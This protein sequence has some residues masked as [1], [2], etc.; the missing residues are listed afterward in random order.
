MT[1][2]AFA[3]ALRLLG[4]RAFFTAELV[5]RLRDKGYSG[6]EVREA[7]DRCRELGYL[8]DA[9]VAARFVELRAVSRG[10]GPR[11]LRAE[12]LKRGA[13][14]EVAAEASRLDPE[15]GR[16][17]LANALERAERRAPEGWWRLHERRARMVSSLINR[18]F[19]TRAAIEAVDRLAAEREK[20][21]HAIDDER[22][23]PHD[24]P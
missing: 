13:P 11:R 9:A 1:R 21:D 4:R 2:S 22:G 19:D 15:T 23:D 6:A 8:D 10:W 20:T 3:E 17:A 18:G 16:R 24:I 14:A 12:L 5:S 7:V